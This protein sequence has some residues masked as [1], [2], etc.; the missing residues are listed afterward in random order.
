MTPGLLQLSGV[1]MDLIYQ[2]EQVPMPGEEAIVSEFCMSAGGGY[3]AMVAAR[4]WN[5]PTTYAGSLGQGPL[6]ELVRTQLEIEGIALIEKESKNGDQGCCTVLIDSQGERTFIAREGAEGV[7]SDA[8]LAAVDPSQFD[9]ILVSG[10]PLV[11]EHSRNTIANWI[12]QLPTDCKLVFDPCPLVASIPKDIL[13]TVMN[14]CCWISC[15]EVE[16]RYLTGLAKCTESATTLASF[17]PENGG[18]VVRQ[19]RSGCTLARNGELATNVPGYVVDTVDTN[20][21]GDT[22]IGSFIACLAGGADPVKA[23]K[24]AN[25]AAALSTTEKG[26]AT[27]PRL[28]DVQTFITR[29]EHS[30]ANESAHTLE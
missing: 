12:D 24:F 3:N 13:D 22:H 28:A 9:W 15:N 30:N 29:F 6:A 5:M 26:P 20:G 16:A 14:Q 1:I 19:G 7:V 11:Y 23:C 27:A 21:A 17:L 4:R 18:V 2:V 10:Y 25:A 8:Q